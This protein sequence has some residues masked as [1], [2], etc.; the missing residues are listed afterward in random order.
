MQ[1]KKEQQ[2]GAET[3]KNQLQDSARNTALRQQ[4]AQTADLLRLFSSELAQCPRLAREEERTLT[5]ETYA[6]WR[7][8]LAVRQHCLTGLTT[9]QAIGPEE[10]VSEPRILR[11]IQQLQGR[12]SEERDLGDTVV[13]AALP[14]GIHALRSHLSH[15]RAC[16]DELVRRNLRLIV[17]LA[18]RYQE[19]G[20]G[21]LD[22]VQEGVLG[23]MRAI[24]KFD[25][26][27]EVAF[28]SYAVWWIRQAFQQALCQREGHKVGLSGTHLPIRF[29]SLDTPLRDDQNSTLADLLSCPEEALPE[30]IASSND[31]AQ[32]L[33]RALQQLPPQEADILRLRFGLADGIAHTYEAISLHLGLSREQT[34]L[35]EQRALLRLKRQLRTERKSTS[36]TVPVSLRADWSAREAR[37]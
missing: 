4:V 12:L 23:L 11:E 5:R 8:L 34:R 31:E 25:P 19:R 32:Q 35:R 28:S 29:V 33:R 16:R 15:F 24:E 18:R 2:C 13:T 1:G 27:R 6:A 3:M 36:P 9:P 26:E 17:L 20:I 22:L 21:L 10:Q 14:R 30:E 7:R 37:L